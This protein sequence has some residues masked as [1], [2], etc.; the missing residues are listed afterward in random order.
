MYKQEVFNSTYELVNFLNN[1]NINISN[2]VT[3]MPIH[4]EA[5]LIYNLIYLER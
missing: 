4:T 3:V 5:F 2:I 1:N